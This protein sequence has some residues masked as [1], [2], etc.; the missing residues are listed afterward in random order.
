LSLF[1]GVHKKKQ[2]GHRMRGDIH[3]LILGDPGT[4]KSQ[5][6]KAASKLSPRAVYTSGQ[7][8]TAAG[9]TAAVLRDEITGGMTLE[10]G[11]LVLADGGVAAIDEFDKMR[12]SDR[13]AIHEAME[14]QSYHYNTEILTTDGQRFEIGRLVDTLMEEHAKDVIQGINCQILPFDGIELYTT[15]FKRIF[16]SRIHRI[17]RHDAPR[18]FYKFTFTNGRA[19]TVT[20]EHPMFVF[21]N[22][23]LEC[24]RADACN[25]DDFI[26][27]PSYLPNSCAPVPLHPIPTRPDPRAKVI[28]IPDTLTE[29]LARILGYFVTEGHSFKGSTVEIGF[30]NMDP[31]L[32]DDFQRL[33]E[34][35]FGMTPSVNK[36]GDGLV[37]LRYLSVEL[38]KWFEYN[39]PECIEKARKKRIP[40]KIMTASK[41]IARA[42]LAS[43]FKGDGSV[44]STSICYR[45]SSKGL[46]EDYQDLLLKLGMQSRIL[47]DHHNESYKTYIRGQ[48]LRDFLH[49]VIEQDDK[50]LD[51]I[52]KII[53][54]TPTKIRHHDVFP[55]PLLPE[56]I[57]LKKELAIA[58]NG[59]FNNHLKRNHGVTRDV[60]ESELRTLADKH[61]KIKETLKALLDITALRE[62]TGYSQQDLARLS[63]IKRGTIDYI[64]RGGYDR[65]KRDETTRTITTAVEA[66]L[67][68]IAKRI[69]RLESIKNADITWDRIKRIERVA[70]EGEHF[71]TH[72]YDLTME[73]DHTFISQGVILH[74]TISIAKAGIVANLNARTSIIAAANPQFGRYDDSRSVGENINLQPTILSRFDLIFIVRDKPDEKGDKDVAEHILKLH[75]PEDK[76][77]PGIAPVDS[78]IDLALL[79]K[80]IKYARRECRPIITQPVAEKIRDFYLKM[81]KPAQGN[82]ESPIPIVARTLEGIVRMCEARAKMALQK[83]VTMDDVDDVTALVEASLGQ[84][85][86]DP[87]RKVFD[88]DTIQLGRSSSKTQK[89]KKM[90]QIIKNLQEENNNQPVDM[91]NI[92]ERAL[93]ASIKEDEANDLVEALNKD[94]RIIKNKSGKYLIADK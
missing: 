23:K 59:Y 16:K 79:K 27:A 7:G 75:V 64:E 25:V 74:N 24:L 61:V 58:Y 88:I 35:E 70:N 60:L 49:V 76:L 57:S 62:G 30:S 42:F 26:P 78:M 34:S 40:G 53:R 38:I 44:E 86:W 63:G 66:H 65:G 5:I 3:I 14:Q 94:T 33:M 93:F 41:D 48:S 45:T 36:R 83:E 9:L 32:L 87:D 85:G 31:S 8:S 10:A 89:L 47:I 1:G 39:F 71:S 80:Y 19:V 43:A 55:T 91:S 11:A 67:C 90:Y 54:E 69:E 28:S 46:A 37:T 50:R 17:S 4:G 52:T 84:V 6:I 56:I 21:K 92:V 68:Q 22:G 15:D 77:P 29:K 73:P 82:A 12:S 2:T 51:K 72:V 13:V 20:P 81:R 18:E